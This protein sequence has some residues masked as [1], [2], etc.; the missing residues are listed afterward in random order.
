MLAGGIGIHGYYH[1]V[2]SPCRND[3][4]EIGCSEGIVIEINEI[5]AENYITEMAEL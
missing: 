1:C 2:L 3:C 5:L 4:C